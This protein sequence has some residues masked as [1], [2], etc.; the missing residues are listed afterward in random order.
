MNTSDKSSLFQYL[1]DV[2]T[3]YQFATSVLQVLLEDRLMH[4]QERHNSTTTAIMTLKVGDIVKA[5]V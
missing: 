1:Q 4:H 5:H 3:K 2:S